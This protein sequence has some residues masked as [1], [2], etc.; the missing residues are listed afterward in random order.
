MLRKRDQWLEEFSTARTLSE[1]EWAELR[2]KR[3]EPFRREHERVSAELRGLIAREPNLFHE[4]L[5]LA[6]YACGNEPTEAIHELANVNGPDGLQELLHFTCLRI[7]CS[8][9]AARGEKMRIRISASLRPR[10]EG[11]LSAKQPLN[12]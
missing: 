3:E 1:N 6:S 11:Q 8:P 12:S 9:R 4:L 5:E 2:E 7:S 10:T